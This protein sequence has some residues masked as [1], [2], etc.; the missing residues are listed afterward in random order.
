MNFTGRTSR[1]NL[2]LII[3]IFCD[4]CSHYFCGRW[5]WFMFFSCCFL[6]ICLLLFFGKWP[7]LGWRFFHTSK[8]MFVRCSRI[9]DY[10]KHIWIIFLFFYSLSLV[11]KK[12]NKLKHS[13]LL[14]Y[15]KNS[16]MHKCK[17]LFFCICR[18]RYWH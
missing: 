18:Q 11:S 16:H 4:S 14:T 12:N 5:L 15:L 6:N 10:S 8:F 9:N 1:H 13:F 2:P 7:L 17:A 3:T